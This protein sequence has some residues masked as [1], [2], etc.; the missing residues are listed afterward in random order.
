MS[1]Q[2]QA[3][4]PAKK[5]KAP[6]AKQDALLKR[7]AELEAK[8]KAADADKAKQEEAALE[9]VCKAMKID[10]NAVKATETKGP[11]QRV[12]RLFVNHPVRINDR[13]YHG[14]VEV[15]YAIFE[16]IAQALGARR[17]R[18]LGELT[19]HNYILQ[20]I[21][22]GGWAPRLVGRIGLDGEAVSG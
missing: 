5:K 15:P 21:D 20:E 17:Q 6:S 13:V 18:I 2:D 4:K 7:V 11:D 14:H 1:E 16:V 10:P 9:R 19:G 12:I 8:L 22:G 3:A